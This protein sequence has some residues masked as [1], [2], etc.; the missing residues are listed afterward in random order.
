[1]TSN[2]MQYEFNV[3]YDKI[4]S[5]GS[6]GYTDKE[7][8]VLLTKAQ[9]TYLQEIFDPYKSF[10][11]TEKRRKDF[12][13]LKHP[14]TGTLSTSQTG[15]HTN[16]YLYELPT[17]VLYVVQEEAVITASGTC[18]NGTTVKIKPVTE[19]EYNLNIKNPY[20]KPS[21]AHLVWRMDFNNPNDLQVPRHELITDGTFTITTY[22]GRYLKNPQDIVP[23]N[24]DGTTTAA[25]NCEL[26]EIAHRPIVDIAVRMATAITNPP[27]YQVK[28]NEQKINE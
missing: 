9:Q 6:P 26:P 22:R 4:S 19:D 11:E 15:I 20:R 23:Y 12:G 2:E 7:V 13:L 28:L 16:G 21:P 25:V 18:Y 14:F 5:A 1:M 17:D 27:E 10:E 3:L 24:N 8:G